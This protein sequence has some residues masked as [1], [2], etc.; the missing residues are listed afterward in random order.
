MPD[1]SFVVRFPTAPDA[2]APHL[3][4]TT[5]IGNFVYA[6]S[7]MPPG[8]AYM[9][10]GTTCSWNEYMQL[11]SKV[12]GNSGSYELVS[13]EQMIEASPD[14]ESGK[15]IAYMFE[16]STEPGYDG[17]DPSLLK[18]ED[19]RKAGIECPMTTLEQFFEK[20]DWSMVFGA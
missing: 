15:E 19:I 4:V 13:V 17:G 6:V 20:A 16:Y 1:G 2:K 3:D 9:A 14:K 18:A 5:D 10:E 8:K 11:W 12:T 7:K